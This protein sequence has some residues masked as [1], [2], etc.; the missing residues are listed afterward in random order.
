ML[1]EGPARTAAYNLARQRYADKGLI[2]VPPEARVPGGRVETLS[3]HVDGDEQSVLATVSLMT[4][5]EGQLL[6]SEAQWPLASRALRSGRRAVTIQEIGA[7]A[8]A[9]ETL[10]GKRALH[11]LLQGMYGAFVLDRSRDILLAC[12]HPKDA[13]TYCQRAGF[14]MLRMAGEKPIDTV[15]GAPGV[16]LALWK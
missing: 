15:G 1:A 3:A 6:P 8:A 7:L 2:F 10:L 14:R 16:L 11:L 5:A 4:A 9:D 13:E 12:C